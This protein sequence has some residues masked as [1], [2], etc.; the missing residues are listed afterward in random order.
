[1]HARAV[2]KQLVIQLVELRLIVGKA[3][4]VGRLRTGHDGSILDQFVN[5]A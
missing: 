1:M 5:G 3:G 2:A 4:I